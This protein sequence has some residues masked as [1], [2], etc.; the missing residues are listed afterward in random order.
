MNIE[1]T[2]RA[3]DSR[4]IGKLK[5]AA[6]TWLARNDPDHKKQKAVAKLRRKRAAKQTRIHRLR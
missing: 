1:P 4:E 3:S 5:R 2:P 6:A